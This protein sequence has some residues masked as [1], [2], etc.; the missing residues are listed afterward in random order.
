MSRTAAR[1]IA[2]RIAFQLYI[3]GQDIDQ[4]LEHSLDDDFLIQMMAE[5]PDDPDNPAAGETLD[6][7]Q[8][9]YV[10]T[11]VRGVYEHT[12][13]LNGYIEKYAVGR[14]L[15][16]IDKMAAV[17]LR[18]A[19]YEILYLDDVPAAVA[20][21]EAVKIAKNYTDEKT[22]K[23]INGILGSFVRKEQIPEKTKTS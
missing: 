10:E 11:L 21:N 8:K 3:P 6:E 13:E 12:D 23:F 15:A 2:V 7:K 18:I 17:I 1:K 22:V 20:I 5:D 16:R 19:M 14:K 4:V 9:K